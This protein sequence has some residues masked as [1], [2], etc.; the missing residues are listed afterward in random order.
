MIEISNLKFGYAGTRHT[1][2]D[3]LSLRLDEGRIYGLLGKNGTGKSTLLYIISGLLRPQRGD[4]TVDGRVPAKRQREMLQELYVVSETFRFPDISISNYVSLNKA[5]YPRFSDETF[6]RC[7]S[8]FQIV[9]AARL[10]ELSMGQQ[11]RVLISFALATQTK[12][13]LMDEPTNGLDIPAKAQFRKVVAENM[14][15]DR[16]LV[17]STHQVHDIEQLLDHIL[18]IDESGVRLDK[19]VS[20][21]CEQYVFEYRAP[22][23]MDGVIYAEPTLQG[24]AVMAERG[25]GEET[26]VNLELLFNAATSGRV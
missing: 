10:D 22:G 4:V 9:P 7:L 11:K 25:D 12:Y 24:N 3:G 16:T 23:E 5:F 13:L 15:P 17:I 1:V 26:N 18:I 20:E 6:R 14:T 8:D 2:F 21:L 19:S